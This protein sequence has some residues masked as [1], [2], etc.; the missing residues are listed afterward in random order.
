MR[1]WGLNER[2]LTRDAGLRLAWE[3]PGML[4]LAWRRRP[5]GSGKLTRRAE[6][7]R[8][9]ARYDSRVRELT[10]SRRLPARR[11]SPWELLTRALLP[12]TLPAGTL[13]TGALVPR[14][15]LIRALLT[16][17]LLTEALGR[18]SAPLALATLRSGTRLLPAGVEPAVLTRRWREGRLRH[19][20]ESTA[21]ARQLPWRGRDM[22]LG[23]GQSKMRRSRFVSARSTS[24]SP[25]PES[26]VRSA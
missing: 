7:A 8:S 4:W 15:F 21:R 11:R 5:P 24:S 6:A 13:L 17:P 9:L 22:R 23:D 2:H 26:T 3:L 16:R 10:G 18:W 12:R 19:A 1:R 20:C 25:R 14:P